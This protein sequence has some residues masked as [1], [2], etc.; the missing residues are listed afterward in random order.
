MFLE[1][2]EGFDQ[3]LVA[4]YDIVVC[5]LEDVRSFQKIVR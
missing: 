5:Q 4:L 1:L 3:G 2:D